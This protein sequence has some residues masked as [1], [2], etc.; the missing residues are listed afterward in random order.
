[1]TIVSEEPLEAKRIENAVV[2]AP[3]NMFKFCHLFGL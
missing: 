3:V 2:I 1:M